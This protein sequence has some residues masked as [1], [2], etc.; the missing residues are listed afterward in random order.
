MRREE[1]ARIRAWLDTRFHRYQLI[2][3]VRGEVPLPVLLSL[4]RYDPDR[5]S[6]A[7]ACSDAHCADPHHHHHRHDEQF[8]S[9]SFKTATPLSL[10]A[11]RHAASRLPAGVYRA[12]GVVY[13]ADVPDRRAILQVVGRRVDIS[14]A[15]PW[16]ERARCT[17][18]VAIGARGSLDDAALRAAFDPY[19]VSG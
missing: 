17:R 12:K 4:G 8:E 7:Q 14:L 18:L 1:L 19:S 5:D 13:A 10:D 3:A 11:L 15:D 2:E 16:G 6:N 9:W